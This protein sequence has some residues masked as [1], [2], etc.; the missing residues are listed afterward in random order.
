MLKVIK[1]GSLFPI[2]YSSIII[3]KNEKAKEIVQKNT[4]PVSYLPIT[5]SK[6]FNEL[7]Q[8]LVFGENNKRILTVQTLSGTGALSLTA[9]YLKKFEKADTVYFSDPT[10][11]NHFN[12]FKY[13]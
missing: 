8:N 5:G 1:V 3:T 11:P 6:K 7:S 4:Y 13:F 2:F 10:W 9:A 12:I